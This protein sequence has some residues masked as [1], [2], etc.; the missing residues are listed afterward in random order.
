MPLASGY[1]QL[2]KAAQR[3]KLALDSNLVAM[4]PCNSAPGKSCSW[5][6][7][8]HARCRQLALPLIVTT[9]P[10]TACPLY[11]PGL[12]LG[13]GDDQ[14]VEL[15]MVYVV[16]CVPLALFRYSKRKGSLS[17]KAMNRPEV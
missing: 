14:A 8:M 10:L 17:S 4:S 13:P 12:A 9:L 2:T 1:L 16:F 11:W 5:V 6:L 3:D 15:D 7:G